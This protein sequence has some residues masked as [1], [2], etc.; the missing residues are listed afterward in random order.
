V[1]LFFPTSLDAFTAPNP[2]GGTGFPTAFVQSYGQASA[3]YTSRSEAAFLQD[4]WQ[5]TPSL[6]LRAGLRW[7][8]SLLPAFPDTADYRAIQ[9]PPA[10][11]VPGAGPVQLPAGAPL[12]GHDYPANFRVNRDWS[13]SLVSPRVHLSWQATTALRAYG[14]WGRYSGPVNQGIV[15]GIRLFNGQDV[16]TVIRTFIDPP[17]QGPLITW[18]NADGVAQ[19]RRY[20][21]PPAGP[22]TFVIPGDVAMPRMD[23]ASLGLEWN[24]T[25][26]HQVVFDAIQSKGRGFLNVRDVNAYVI[27][28]DP[29]VSPAP[30]QRR[31]DLRYSTL[32]RADGSGGT[33]HESQSLAFTWKPDS[34]LLLKASYTR[35]RTRDN[36]IDWTSDFT[37]ENPFD[38]ASEW[39]PSV[40]DQRH[41]LAT[42]GVWHSGDRASAWTRG[43]SLGWIAT[44]ASGRPHTKLAGY[45]RNF[46]GDGTSDRPEGVGR[47]SETLPSA[48]RVDLRVGRTFRLGEARLEATLEVFNLFNEGQ[49]LEVQNNTASAQPAYGTPVRFGDR[50]QFQFGVRYSF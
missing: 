25:P 50:R 45:D 8:R 12:G 26:A 19:N 35:S 32:N 5:A 29:A 41:R 31:P 4:E 39:G 16:K 42:S 30:I 15:Y 1:P 34:R 46:N 40:Q 13:S 48:G 38:P 17:L 43:W 21:S 49:V 22:T 33:R 3:S 20:A 9:A 2:F 23:L 11:T 28:V 27:Y 6:L 36:F 7:E 37:P 14:G 24:P 18:A 47:N 10:V 44:W